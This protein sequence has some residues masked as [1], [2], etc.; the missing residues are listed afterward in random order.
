[1]QFY[2][3][4]QG[5]AFMQN[6]VMYVAAAMFVLASQLAHAA[7]QTVTRLLS[8]LDNPIALAPGKYYA[9]DA[10]TAIA[11]GVEVQ[12]GS[13]AL[14][15]NL[16]ALGGGGKGDFTLRD[17]PGGNVQSLICQAYLPK[18]HTLK[19]FGFQ[20]YD[21]EGESLFC[22]I[23]ADWQGWKRIEMPLASADFKQAYP[24]PKYNG[25]VDLPLKGIHFAFYVNEAGPTSVIVDALE[26]TYLQEPTAGNEALTCQ[27]QSA[28]DVPLG[29]PYEAMLV[30]TNPQSKTI[31]A[32]VQIVLQTD[33]YQ[34]DLDLPDPVLGRDHATSATSVTFEGDKQLGT[35]TLTDGDKNTSA[36]TGYSS[37]PKWKSIYQLVT[38][39]K[40]RI[41][42]A[43]KWLSGDANWVAKVDVLSSMDG[44]DYTPVAG[45][46]NV[47]FYKKWGE[48]SFDLKQPFAARY[49]KLYYHD[50]DKLLKSICTPSSL[51]I[52]D[53]AADEST[54]IPVTGT[55]LHDQTTNIQVPAMGYRVVSLPIEK[56]LAPGSYALISRVTAQQKIAMA[57][58]AVFC[59]PAPMAKIDASS[60]FGLNAS[61][62]FLASEHV[63]LG[64][65]WVRFENFKWP[66]VSGEA[67][68]YS[69]NPG[70][71]PW[72]LDIDDAIKTYTD[73]G[74]NVLPMMFLTPEWASD[75][76]EGLKDKMKLS[77]VPRSPD[78]FAQ[79]AYQTAARYGSKKIP[80]DKLLT[81]DKVSGK[82]QIKYFELG[83]E[84]DLNPIKGNKLPTWGAWVGTMDQFWE[85]YKAGALAVKQADPD[86]KVPSPGFAGMTTSVVDSMRTYTY[87]DGTHPIDYCDMLSVHYYSGRTPPEIAT[88]DDNNSTNSKST[89]DEHVRRTVAWRDK[90]KPGIPIWLTETGYDTGGPIGTNERTQS[91]RLPRVVMIA[92]HNR[93]PRVRFNPHATCRCRCPA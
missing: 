74:L 76:V 42:T 29:Q 93:L 1:M 75:P 57:G 69:F 52:Y 71:A 67:D 85:I 22:L 4:Y 86:A 77:R 18:G 31:D 65:G 34:T 35:N 21:S 47:D 90:N 7:P 33:P 53:G 51:M 25:K 68:K 80:A 81:E 6:M 59:E 28:S 56:P 55:K 15:M 24:Q 79:F 17:I 70:P 92:L 88:R 23:P 49:I 40:T 73:A 10:S 16:T 3:N 46:Q 2:C 91:A 30:L 41:I 60:Q 38:L 82:N 84:P 19:N 87:A 72:R 78:L 8:T 50:N 61:R 11:Q 89:F 26:G 37:K 66:M 12:M 62:W 13:H 58:Q 27:L 20:V 83:N 43:M 63:K 54:Q 48:N 39:D 36:T 9:S 44:K 5:I 64:I 14:S 45:L 32:Q